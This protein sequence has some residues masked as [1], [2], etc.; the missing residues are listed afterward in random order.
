KSPYLMFTN[1]H[2]IRRID[3]LKSEYTQVVPTLK[4]AVALDVD[5]STNKMFWCDLYHR[6]IYSAYINKASD[7]S[8]QVTLVDSLHSPEGLA[9]DWV[10]KNIYWTDSG[11]KSISVATGD[12]RKRKVLIATELSE[13]RAIAVDPHQGFMYWSD[14]GDQAKIEKAGM[15]GVDRQILVSDHIEWPNGITLDL[16]NRRLYWVD[17]KLH[18][19][20][21]VDLN[22]DNRKV[23]LSSHHHLGHPFA[24]TVFEVEEQVDLIMHSI[25]TV[26][27]LWFDFFSHMFFT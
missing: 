19:L 21:S 10:H 24:L 11:N 4:N 14:W 9:V 5:V 26:G 22:G 1:R 7:S 13:P 27:M 25:Q 8:Q 18:L 15:N 6:K 17:S 3:L 2:E 16:S 23:L 12:G 20:S